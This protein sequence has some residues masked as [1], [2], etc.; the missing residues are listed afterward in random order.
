M[1]CIRSSLSVLS[2]CTMPFTAALEIESQSWERASATSENG[3]F[4]KKILEIKYQKNSTFKI[5]ST[6]I[7]NEALKE[8]AH[9]PGSTFFDSLCKR[10]QSCVT[11]S[12]AH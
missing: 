12:I 2:H 5:W 6:A 4:W 7:N 1:H 3:T 8:W 10:S 11:S 9:L